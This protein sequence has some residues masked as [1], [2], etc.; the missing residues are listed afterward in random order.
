MK[1]L[2]VALIRATRRSVYRHGFRPKHGSIF[3]SPSLHLHYA[4]LDYRKSLEHLRKK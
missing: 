2:L 1:K 4:L 3:H